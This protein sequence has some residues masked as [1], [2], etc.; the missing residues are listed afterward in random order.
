MEYPDELD[1]PVQLT[2]EDFVGQS[3]DMFTRAHDGLQSEVDFI[4]FAL[5]G[6]VGPEA[7]EEVDRCQIRL[8]A[9]QGIAPIPPRPE[10]T[11]TR[12]ID[13]VIGVSR[14]LPYTTALS[15]WP[16][17]PFRE[18]L[19]K[20]NHVKS[21]A[22]NAEGAQIQVPMHRIPN[23]PLGKV[24]QRHVVRIFFPRLYAAASE[25]PSWV[26]LSQEDFALIYDKCL[27]PLMLEHL[28]DSRDRWP[29]SYNIALTHSR[30]LTGSIALNSVDVP[31]RVLHHIAVPLLTRL[32]EEKPA[33]K[34]AYYVHEL[35]G[36]KN[37]AMHD[38][39]DA[40]ARRL[41]LDDVFEHVDDEDLDPRQWHVD[42]ALTI[43][44]PGHVVTWRESSHR[45]TTALPFHQAQYRVCTPEQWNMHFDRFFP[46]S[47]VKKGAKARVE[48]R[49]NFKKCTYFKRYIS[50]VQKIEP[51]TLP[52][53]RR[54][55]RKEFDTLAWVPYTQ[56]D[57]MWLTSAVPGRAWKML[58]PVRRDSEQ[59]G[60]AIGI[61]PR[62][63][64]KL[65]TLRTFPQPDESDEDEAG[66]EGDD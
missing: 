4:R 57:R 46:T 54:A 12:D 42:V 37:A 64:R 34:D 9:Q 45:E 55:L 23:V 26:G 11:I 6:R 2:M 15:I 5:A 22:Y 1:D 49:Q 21:R 25:D 38:G 47:T 30:T 63:Q 33:F 7:D 44:L 56:T 18:T 28:P 52:R 14:S 40:V 3:Q 60:P 8:N 62:F 51:A 17:P 59:A 13:S 41:A 16:V 35:R 20:D 36:K 61:N 24:E 10:S 53:L 50:L 39:D 31:W 19:T 43:G 65:V 58:P 32:G 27:R 66:S 48:D 29:T